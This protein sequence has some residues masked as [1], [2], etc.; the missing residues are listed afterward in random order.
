MQLS[1]SALSTQKDCP[2][3]FWLDRNKKLGRPQ[4]I[5][6]GVPGAVDNILKDGLEQ[7]RGSLPPILAADLRLE[8]FVL[9]AGTDLPKMRH[10]KSNPY[11]MKDE[12]GNIIVGAFDDLL[13]H[14]GADTYAYLD[15]KT[16]GKEPSQEFG[17]RYYQSQCDIYTRFLLLGG[18]KVASFGV[19]L[20]F[21]PVSN[22]NGS[23]DF[24]TMPIFLTPNPDNAEVLFKKAIECLEGPIPDASND[25]EYCGRH[26]ALNL[27]GF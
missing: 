25:C 4:G 6:S 18:K 11:K 27:N 19:L 9:Y 13:H 21:W 26:N 15:Y 2:R 22:G 23:V 1:Y 8:G 14:P 12:K 17:E 20:F 7:Y 3:C 16:T 10:W 5:K 24:K